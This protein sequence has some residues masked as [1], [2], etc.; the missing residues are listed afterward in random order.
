MDEIFVPDT[1][2]IVDGRF[3]NFLMDHFPCHVII[4]EALLAEIEHQA[5]EGRSIGFAGLE[6]LY[7]L[8]KFMDEG[9]IVLS[10]YG[11][12]PSEWQ[13]KRAKSGEIDDLI[14]QVALENN[15]TLVTG[16]YVQKSIGE[17]KG[18]RVLYL[19]T[20]KTVSKKIEEYFGEDT[21][22]VHLK[23]GTFPRFKVGKPGDWRVV[24]GENKLTREDLINL[25]NDIVERAKNDD[26]SIIEMDIRGATVVQLGPIR[27]VITRPPVSE[28]IEVTAVRPTRKLNLNDYELSP[29]MLERLKNKAEGIIVSG[30]PGAGKST[31]VQALAEFYNSM[32][33]IVKTLEKPRDLQVSDEITQLTQ[34]EGSMEKT[35]DLLLLVRPDYTVYDEIR[36]PND[37][38]VFTDLRL[39]GVG[40]VGVIHASRAIDSIQRFIG[41]VDLGVIPQV[42]DTVIFMENGKINQILEINY[43]VKI[44]SGMM[45]EDLARPVIEISDFIEKK[46][47]Y[48]M[49]TFGEQIVVV[50]VKENIESKII[51]LNSIIKKIDKELDDIP[52]SVNIGKN[53]RLILRIPEDF[54]GKIIGKS[55]KNVKKLEE[56]IGMPI[57]IERLENNEGR[58]VQVE[59]KGNKIN[60][61]IGPEYRNKM[62]EIYIEDT[63]SIVARASKSGVIQ[64]KA[65]SL[66]GKMIK[67]AL[68]QGSK[69]EFRV[70]EG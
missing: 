20:N 25:I 22:S 10:F 48:E 49:Y 66:Q 63:P 18:I 47:L 67:K 60:L 38:V 70:L 62:I 7:K 57:D 26:K 41:K 16:D 55:G 40:M 24:Y 21:M 50:P 33:K 23:E 9:K 32:G 1:S 5:N 4:S 64:I 2:V 27:I 3:S 19:E 54:I 51:D 13:I 31:F 35:G 8:R 36:T 15:A 56:N 68:T 53:G 34:I 61:Y 14:R 65:D 17:I 59:I 39:A 58:E 43:V 42:L 52:H 69:I 12:R 45:E 30:R 6:E 11:K 29:E 44:P 28:A 37:F 46:L